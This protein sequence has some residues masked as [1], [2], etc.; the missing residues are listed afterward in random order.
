MKKK[1]YNSSKQFTS[2]SNVTVRYHE[3]DRMG[4]AHHSNYLVW[5]EVARLKLLNKIFGISYNN[6][7][8]K[9]FLIPVLNLR[10]NYKKP[11]FFNDKLRISCSIKKLSK[12]LI[13]FF[14]FY[15]ISLKQDKKNIKSEAKTTHVFVNNKMFPI[16]PPS[17]FTKQF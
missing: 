13:K 17:F 10:I 16:K 12:S 6:I 4:I 11:V 5:M 3:V 8:E 14:I 9:G 15:K 7:E 2:I 1:L